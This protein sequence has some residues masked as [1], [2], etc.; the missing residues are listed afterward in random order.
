MSSTPKLKS[1]KNILDTITEDTN[2]IASKKLK[3]DDT[4]SIRSQISKSSKKDTDSR[5]IRTRMDDT[6]SI[7]TQILNHRGGKDD[8]QSIRSS[9]SIRTQILNDG[10]GKDDTQSIR[11]SKSIRTQI[12]NYGGGKDDT[13]SI[14]SSKSI[15]TQILNDGGG[16]DVTKIV[17]PENVLD[18]N[19]INTNIVS[20]IRTNQD[21][22]K[23]KIMNNI[24]HENS[25]VTLKSDVTGNFTDIFLKD[26]INEGSYNRV[27]N[28]TKKKTVEKEL[29]IRISNADNDDIIEDEIKGIKIQYNL[30]SQCPYIGIIADYGRVHDQNYSI[31]Q[32][33][34]ISLSDMLRLE[35]VKYTNFNVI[36][37]FM[38]NL[39][40]ALQ[41]IHKNGYA[42]LDLKSC[43][44][45]L[46][47]DFS[48]KDI[49]SKLH[50]VVIDF[51]ASQKFKTEACTVLDEQ[52]ASAA[53]SPPELLDMKFSKKSDIW[54]YGVICYMICVNKFF[55]SAGCDKLFLA[56]D[57]SKKN[58]DELQERLTNHFE[59][60]FITKIDTK[61]SKKQKDLLIDFF[62]CI[63]QT[64]VTHR[65]NSSQLLK[66]ELFNDL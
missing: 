13:Q 29:I 55:F 20:T 49:Q 4:R 58:I 9:K 31:I 34:G 7:R 32:K 51:G 35:T 48:P 61:I 47:K 15:R 63:F 3:E 14:R 8:T 50:F 23:T 11:S 40:E 57:K 17:S 43:N 28:F 12:L 66:H 33:Y 30:C 39:L 19:V 24:I 38:K 60:E 46:N 45:L 64:K 62:K 6:Q 65:S 10:G 21:I 2:S 18:T 5:S 41:C 53:F 59:N 56:K 52:M 42:H 1:V 36:I 27:Y 16:K 37:E 25:K 22:I 54:A 26:M 44:I